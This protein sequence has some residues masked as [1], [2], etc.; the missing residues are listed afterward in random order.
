[1]VDVEES[2]IKEAEDA[3]RDLVNWI[4]VWNLEE[5]QE[6]TKKIEDETVEELKKKLEDIAKK[7]S[8]MDT[9]V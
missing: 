8:G 1:M 4:E 9:T 5:V 7:V 2:N 6:G 3:I